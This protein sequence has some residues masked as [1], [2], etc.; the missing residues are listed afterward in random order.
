MLHRGEDFDQWTERD[1][2]VIEL[3]QVGTR[4]NPAVVRTLQRALN[5]NDWFV[6][7]SALESLKEL[8]VGS[9]VIVGILLQTLMN[10]YS[11][12]RETVVSSLGEVE[13]EDVPQ[14][15]Q[16]LIALTHCLHDSDDDV[17][18]EAFISIRKLMDGRTF[19]RYRW[20]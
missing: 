7:S 17:R 18:K 9:E 2:L 6:R 3:G 1:R 15:Y 11:D 8:E 10:M 12:V 5:D 13:V 4:N 20:L 14:L 16:I 19:P